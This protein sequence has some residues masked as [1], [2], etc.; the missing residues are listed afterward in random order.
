MRAKSG[1]IIM[2]IKGLLKLVKTTETRIA[3]IADLKTIAVDV[4]CWLHKVKYVD[5][6]ALALDKMHD[7]WLCAFQNIFEDLAKNYQVI[8]V[9]DGKTPD[10]KRSEHERRRKSHPDLVKM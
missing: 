4:S 9:F 10:L 5:N 8:F 6:C 2:G 3:D 1:K 7:G